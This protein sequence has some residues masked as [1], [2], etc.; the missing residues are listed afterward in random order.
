MGGSRFLEERPLFE[1]L[2]D[3]ELLVLSARRAEAFG[4]FYER[5]A[6]G[7][8]K[9]FARR[10]LD[11]EAAAELTAETFAQAFVSRTRFRPQG[12]GGAGWLYAVARHQLGRFHRRGRVA[13]TARRRLGMPDR[14]ISD[15]DYERIEELMDLE[16]IRAAIAD[17]YRLLSQE[18][19]DAVALRVV[20]GRSYPEVAVALACS[21]QAA[22]ARVSR[23]LKRLGDLLELDRS[24]GL[25]IERVGEESR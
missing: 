25:S 21:E 4:A 19:R 6:E 10:T 7:V 2:D 18:Q 11:P 20:E 3:E 24:N 12:L 23:A 8:L 22:R 13:A 15:H 1:D 17:A 16:G 9:F 14:G 5:H